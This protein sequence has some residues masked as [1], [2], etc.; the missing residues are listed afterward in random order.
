LR[1][2]SSAIGRSSSGSTIASRDGEYSAIVSIG[3]S[4][5]D[6]RSLASSTSAGL[7]S[8]RIITSENWRR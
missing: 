4:I 2:T 1:T 5:A 7:P 8:I 3:R 6:T